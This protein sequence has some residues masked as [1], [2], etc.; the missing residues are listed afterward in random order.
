ML[1]L[2]ECS[3]SA[4]MGR[5]QAGPFAWVAL[6]AS[7]VIFLGHELLGPQGQ[8]CD[9]PRSLGRVLLCAR[10]GCSVDP[11]WYRPCQSLWQLV[12]WTVAG[13]PAAGAGPGAP[14]LEMQR[15]LPRVMGACV[16]P[17]PPRE[18]DPGL[19]WF[20]RCLWSVSCA[21]SA[22]PLARRSPAL[23]S[24]GLHLPQMRVWFY[25]GASRRDQVTRPRCTRP[26]P[27]PW[28]GSGLWAEPGWATWGGSPRPG[29]PLLTCTV[30]PGA[31]RTG[32]HPPRPPRTRAG[33]RSR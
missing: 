4:A 25:R 29:D 3:R 1:G 10:G 7:V 33:R 12:R 30:L 32:L 5:P 15:P 2:P 13:S 23:S 26:D 9:P 21:E 11:V 17:R 24:A 31:Q 8:S 22:A 6:P 18:S 27:G 16:P 14:G 19:E 28:G 20:P